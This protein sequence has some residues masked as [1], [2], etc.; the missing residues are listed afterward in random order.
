MK[1]ES[2]H[3]VF[4]NMLEIFFKY[5]LMVSTLGTRCYHLHITDGEAEAQ[6]GKSLS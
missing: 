6:E 3:A 5:Y 2:Y 1:C 4:E